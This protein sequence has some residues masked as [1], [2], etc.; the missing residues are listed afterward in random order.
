VDGLCQVTKFDLGCC[1]HSLSMLNKLDWLTGSKNLKVIVG[2]LRTLQIRSGQASMTVDDFLRSRL[3]YLD[4]G[5]CQ[6]RAAALRTVRI[7]RR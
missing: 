7:A 6:E 2:D 1:G 3:L 5:R 4:V